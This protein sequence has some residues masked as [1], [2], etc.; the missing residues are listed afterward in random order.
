MLIFSRKLTRRA[1]KR[2]LIKK[3]ACRLEASEHSS[4]SSGGGVSS[5]LSGSEYNHCMYVCGILRSHFCAT[6]AVH[7]GVTGTYVVRD[8]SSYL[9]H[10]SE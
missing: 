2:V 9:T 1:Y 7:S 8:S 4:N 10:V 3:T 5:I 6:Q